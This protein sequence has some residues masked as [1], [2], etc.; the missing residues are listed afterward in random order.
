M[1]V[2]KEETFD[3]SKGLT[4]FLGGVTDLPDVL[5]FLIK[6]FSF[7]CYTADFNLFSV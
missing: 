6:S 4:L 1:N 7:S 2:L 3:G 5:I